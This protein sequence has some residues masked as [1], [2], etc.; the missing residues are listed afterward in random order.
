[1]DEPD[2]S[3]NYGRNPYVGYDSAARPFLYDGE[4]PPHGI[5]ALARVVRVGDRAWPVERVR[6]FGPVSEAGVTITWSEGQASALDT[7]DIGQGRE[8]G[9]IRVRD[10][11]G[12]D[13]AHDVLFAFAFH[14]FFPD[15]EWMIGR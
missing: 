7:A 13:V 2:W 11:A 12:R 4:P 10:G 9:T 3:R 8:V 5:P 14:A 1:M 6:D 15:G